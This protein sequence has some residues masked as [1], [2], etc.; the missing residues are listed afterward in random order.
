VDADGS[1]LQMLIERPGDNGVRDPEWSPDGSRI[2]YMAY[3]VPKHP[4]EPAGAFPQV[5]IVDVDGSNP[6]KL[7]VGGWCCTGSRTG[8]SWALD[9]TGITF[10]SGSRHL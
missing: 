4:P 3:F 6:R 8:L 7:F 10:I 1:N 5:W 2:A 9:G